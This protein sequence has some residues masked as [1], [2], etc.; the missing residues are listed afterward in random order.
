M[1]QLFIVD[2]DLDELTVSELK[3][4]VSDVA[5]AW[6]K[7]ILNYLKSFGVSAYT[8]QPVYDILTGEE[9]FSADNAHTDG[10]Y[11]WYESEI[12]YFETYNLKLSKEFIEYVSARRKS[13]VT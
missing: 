3:Q 4:F 6:K 10:V 2:Y 1:N 9:V 12:Y 13:K 11:T 7:E 8:S 5:P